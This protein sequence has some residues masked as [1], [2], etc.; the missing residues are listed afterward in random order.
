MP[1]SYAPHSLVPVHTCPAFDGGYSAV[2]DLPAPK[3]W[4]LH[5]YSD[6]DD[7]VAEVGTIERLIGRVRITIGPDY[8]DEHIPT[9]DWSAVV[10]PY[11]Q[12]QEDILNTVVFRGVTSV[13]A[14]LYR[15]GYVPLLSVN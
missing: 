3:P 10:V 4:L 2:Y 1:Y 11:H 15:M 5:V 6:D 13:T 14:V 12:G 9:G 8:I 7:E